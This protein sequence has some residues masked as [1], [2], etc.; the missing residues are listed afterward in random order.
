MASVSRLNGFRPVKFKNGQ[1]YNGGASVYFVPA[2]NADVIMV[3]DVVKLAGDS[4]SPTGAP[5]VARHAGGATEAAVGVVV[6]IAYSGMGDTQNVPP[7]TDLNTPVFRRAST[8]RYLLVADDPD[9]VFE[10][11]ASASGSFTSV[12]V[13]LNAGVRATAGNTASGASG[14]D[15]DLAAKAVTATLPLKIVGFPYRPDNSVGDAFVSLY[16]V[17]NNH[18]Y[19]GGTGTAG[20]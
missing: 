17:I 18:Q 14:M 9:L 6:G 15:V 10:A 16:V 20:V 1:P 11:Q 5:T 19:Q 13:G 7:V 2:T 12:D 3:G 8:D 4:R